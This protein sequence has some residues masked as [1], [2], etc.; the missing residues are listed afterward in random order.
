MK[1]K[2]FNINKKV[3]IIA[4]IGNNHEGSLKNAKK[5]INLAARAGVDAVKFQTFKTKEFVQKKNKKRF[6]QL[7]RF[8]L[9]FKDFVILKNLAH[10]KKIKFISTPLD[11]TSADFLSKNADLIKVASGDNNFFPLIKKLLM[12]KKSII[13]ST[14]MTKM[15]DIK[16]LSKFI[17]RS[18]GVREAHKRVSLL[19]CVTSYPVDIEYA[20]LNSIPYLIKNSDFLI[21]YSDHTIGKEAC[22]SAVTLGAKIIEKHFTLDKNFS[23]FRD[24][25][26]SADYNELR[27]IVISIRKIEK[28]LGKSE[29]KIQPPEKKFIKIARRSV[30]AKK[31]IK[32]NE[33]I[34]VKNAEFLR[35]ANS[36][37]FLTLNNFLGKKTKKRINKN[38]NINK[39]NLY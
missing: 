25:S 36:N 20:N 5:L 35:P 1:I 31:D 4:E 11:L 22:L 12:S 2:N 8:E 14:G 15:V 3:F 32:I 24:H 27:E 10:K 39:I 6:N 26:L 13:I 19:H 37:D 28:L 21:G 7:K 38:Q 9:S 16:D 33:K 34:T 18:L 23:K 30:Y 29:K 17:Y